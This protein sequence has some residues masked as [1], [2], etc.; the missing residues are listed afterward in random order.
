L[1]PIRMYL[2]TSAIF[3]LLFFTLKGD[4]LQIKQNALSKKDRH[5]LAQTLQEELAKKPGDT[6]LLRQLALIKD[7]TRDLTIDQLDSSRQLKISIA[8]SGKYQSVANY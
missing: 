7:T 3:F 2:F 6:S 4:V 8:N 1:H 5:E